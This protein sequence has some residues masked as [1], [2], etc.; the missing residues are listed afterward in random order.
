MSKPIY[1]ADGHYLRI[2][3]GWVILD[4]TVKRGLCRAVWE[5]G[6]EQWPSSG[7]KDGKPWH[8]VLDFIENEEVHWGAFGADECEI[9]L[10]LESG[11]LE[12]LTKTVCISVEPEW[13]GDRYELRP[14]GAWVEKDARD[15]A[16]QN[17][18]WPT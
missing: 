14:I 3:K 6:C 9:R 18:A 4:C 7:I 2:D 17:A 10:W 15:Y 16:R 1:H 5:C 12:L 13:D 11:G 8:T